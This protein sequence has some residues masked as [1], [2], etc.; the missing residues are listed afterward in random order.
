MLLWICMVIDQMCIWYGSF[1]LIKVDHRRSGRGQSGSGPEWFVHFE[2]S[3]RATR[4][5]GSF[6]C[7]R[8]Q[9]NSMTI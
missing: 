3:F 2:A 4:R 5:P 8:V 7:E 6:V 1:R 9:H